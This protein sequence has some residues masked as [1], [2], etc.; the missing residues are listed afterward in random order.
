[1]TDLTL[2]THTE[3][4]LAAY[5]LESAQ[6]NSYDDNTKTELLEESISSVEQCKTVPQET[7]SI[8]YKQLTSQIEA[9]RFQSLRESTAIKQLSEKLLNK[10]DS[11]HMDTAHSKTVQIPPDVTVLFTTPPET[12]I[13]NPPSEV[14]VVEQYETVISNAWY[15]YI[16]PE[17]SPNTQHEERQ[18]ESKE[19]ALQRAITLAQKR[20]IP[21]YLPDHSPLDADPENKH[22]QLQ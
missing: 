22:K 18:A 16:Q 11:I 9:N 4:Q 5:L 19:H 7:I 17:N 14:I 15:S 3:Q 1:M 6:Y 20:D 2:N 12:D 10:T 21:I 8:L 13:E